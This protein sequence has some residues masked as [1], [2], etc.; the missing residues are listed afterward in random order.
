M[1][2]ERLKAALDPWMRLDVAQ[3]G[4]S[5][6]HGLVVWLFHILV[7]DEGRHPHRGDGVAFAR[8]QH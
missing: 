2:N 8:F 7:V 5:T 4:R 1:G 6:Y 3:Y